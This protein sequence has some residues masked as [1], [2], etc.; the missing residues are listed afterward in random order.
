MDQGVLIFRQTTLVSRSKVVRIVT[1]ATH[2]LAYRYAKQFNIDIQCN[3]LVI[4][5]T[6]HSQEKGVG[7]ELWHSFVLIVLEG[8]LYVSS[9]SVKL[10]GFTKNLAR[11]TTLLFLRFR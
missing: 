9:V 2:T 8:I 6:Q 4:S 3:E 11:D 5:K 7:E 10:S 1:N